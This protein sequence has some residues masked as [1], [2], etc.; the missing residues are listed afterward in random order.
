MIP[1]NNL[2]LWAALG[3]APTAA[4][5]DG[6]PAAGCPKCDCCGCCET[7]TCTCTTCTCECCVDECPA[8]GVNAERASRCDSGCCGA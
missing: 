3:L 5:V 6:S 8:A 1:M 4:P 2:L 7:G